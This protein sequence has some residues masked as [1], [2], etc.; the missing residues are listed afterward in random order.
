MEGNQ[1]W[2]ETWW[3]G[4]ILLAF[5]INL[6]S[7]YIKPLLDKWWGKYS[8]R[9]E[10]VNLKNSTLFDVQIQEMLDDETEVMYIFSM[11]NQSYFVIFIGIIEIFGALLFFKNPLFVSFMFFIGLVTVYFGIQIFLKNNLMLRRDKL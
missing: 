9:Q 6:A 10:K 11:L 1:N 5:V 2:L 3:G 8:D 7:S 4:G